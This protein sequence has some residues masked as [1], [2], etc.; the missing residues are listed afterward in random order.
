MPLQM[1]E[2]G[3]GSSGGVID[4]Y[5]PYMQQQQYQQQQQ[6]ANWQAVMNAFQ[7]FARMKAENDFL[8]S[9]GIA[10]QKP[11]MGEANVGSPEWNKFAQEQMQKGIVVTPESG[12]INYPTGK[13]QPF[14]DQSKIPPGMKITI[15]GTGFEMT[16]QQPSMFSNMTVSPDGDLAYKLGDT[17]IP[18]KS[19]SKSGISVKGPESYAEQKR[20]DIL[21]A[22]DRIKAGE[23][24]IQTEKVNLQS[25]YPDISYDT[26]LN[27]G[28]VATSVKKQ[29]Q[30][31]PL[32]KLPNDLP[33]VNKSQ[34]GAIVKA[35]G[36]PIAKKV[37]GKWQPI[38]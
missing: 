38:Q 19:I 27:L 22:L 15:P 29:S 25:N 11:V 12:K 30:N 23:S 32:V 16:G 10:G 35:N 28:D 4:L 20:A 18:L 37:N 36:V 17:Y 24:D 31:R 13:T 9:Q 34:E 1:Q 5:S 7:Q 26:L 3:G 6:Q 14:F 8:K 33:D 21:M 2:T